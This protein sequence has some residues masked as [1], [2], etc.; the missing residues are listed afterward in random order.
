[1]LILE[2]HTLV[3]LQVTRETTGIY[4]CEA[5]NEEGAAQ[6]EYNIEVMVPPSIMPDF[7]PTKLEVN[8]GD[9][10]VLTCPTTSS[11]PP[12]TIQWIKDGNPLS[13]LLQERSDEAQMKLSDDQR[14]LTII[15][16]HPSDNGNYSCVATNLA[17]R[18]DAKF[19]VDVLMTPHFEEFNHVAH[20]TIL[21][22]GEVTL[23]CSVTGNPQPKV[24]YT[25][26]T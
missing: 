25:R 6:Q 1:M 3:F 15:E 4:K 12:P 16:A 20:R 2:D 21:T 22:G 23:N 9:S 13:F 10:L 5:V 19:L 8:E 17:G 18:T 11:V 26:Y 14:S 7:Y 24:N